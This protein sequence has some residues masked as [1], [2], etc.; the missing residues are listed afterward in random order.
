M[1]KREIAPIDLTKNTFVHVRGDFQ[2]IG[3][4]F[5]H[6][7]LVD[8]SEPCLVIMPKRG[9]KKILNEK[10]AVIALSSAY[11]YNNPRALLHNSRIFV[12]SMGV[13]DS[14]TNVHKLATI[15][16]DHLTYLLTMPPKPV[17]DKIH[18]ADVTITNQETGES[19]E[20]E[21]YDHV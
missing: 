7:G 15:I 13:T 12:Q 14:M 16:D 19:V 21:I 1:S 9:V 18:G 4:W 2:I 17:S 6:N 5:A 20:R 11:K 10:P 8:D 3:T